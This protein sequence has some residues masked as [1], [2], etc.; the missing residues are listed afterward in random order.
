LYDRERR[1]PSLLTRL[2]LGAILAAAILA[3]P[4]QAATPPGQ[5]KT[6]LGGADYAPEPVVKKA[7]GRQSAFSYVFHGGS[8]P[9]AGRPVVVFL[10][11]WGA[12]NPLVYGGWIDHLA[13]RGYLV[14]YPA[15][16]EVG[17]TR[18]VE[19][20]D[21]TVSLLKEAF[22]ALAADPG[23]KPD[24]SRVALIGHSA[25]AA[26]AVNVAALAG[27]ESLPVPK[28][29]YVVAPGGIAS[30]PKARGIQL[31]D[32]SKI[33]AATILVT[34]I[35]D[36]EFQ[37][38]DRASKRILREASEVPATRK[39]FIRA[40]SDDHG[41]PALSATLAMAGA[42]KEG[43]EA[44][45]I[46]VTPDPPRDPKAKLPPR[47]RWSADMVLTGEQQVLVQ[48]LGSN[49]TDALDYLGLWKV[50]DMAAEAAFAGRDAQALRSDPAFNDMG[51]WSDGWPV[52]RLVVEAPKS[53][54]P[55]PAPARAAPAP[56]KLPVPSR[57]RH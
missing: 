24:L 17:R 14:I 30:D 4:A 11:A 6:G 22:E 51:R 13:R 16:Q 15:F 1:M 40:L 27:S 41:F 8:A 18:P 35:G 20:T 23:A 12:I 2:S 34:E 33:D 37:A 36:R 19:A 38:S 56:S 10:H 52:K 57:R 39:V 9:A 7:V 28:L 31:A 55:G 54:A 47:P 32:L 25:G 49:V 44:A 5:P 48:Q 43:Y 42:T 29:V 3:S 21:R 53:D 50:F 45:A 26:L 46:K